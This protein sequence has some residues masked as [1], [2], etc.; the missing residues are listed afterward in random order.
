MS[1]R[2]KIDEHPFFWLVSAATSGFMAALAVTAMVMEFTGTETVKRGACI[3]SVI[4]ARDYLSRSELDKGYLGRPEVERNYILRANLVDTYLPRAEVNSTFIRKE[5][6]ERLFILRSQCLAAGAETRSSRGEPEGIA[7]GPQPKVFETPHA[8]APATQPP[9]DA[10]PEPSPKPKATARQSLIDRG[11]LFRFSG[12]S[13]SGSELTCDLTVTNKEDDRFLSLE[14][15]RPSRI[16]DEQGREYRASRAAIGASRESAATLPTG[17][18]MVGKIQ[19]EG[20]HPGTTRLQLL[21]I[22]YCFGSAGNW[23]R[24]VIKFNNIDL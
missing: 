2:E 12:C 3:D 6:V 20:V 7:S 22:H 10:T 4:L 19:F 23:T 11:F 8:L 21:E 9:F 17:V 16:I 1:F 13:L 5:E 18:I 14:S 24:P 15:D